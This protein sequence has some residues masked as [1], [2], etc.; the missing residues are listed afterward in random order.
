M[1][2]FELIRVAIFAIL[3]FAMVSVSAAELDTRE[4]LRA[5]SPRLETETP[6]EPLRK[7]SEDMI[8]AEPIEYIRYPMTDQERTIVE[9]VVAAES[10]GEDFDGQCLVAQCIL[11]TA[12]ATGKRPDEVVLEPGQYATPN[13]DCSHLVSEAVSAVFDDG[14]QVTDEPVRYFYAPAWG[15][16]KWHETKLEF[17]LEHGGHRFFKT[18]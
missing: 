4:D 8:P 13:Y 11:N 7:I 16:S 12:E 6:A 17:V 10:M 14:Y 3:I 1:K 5:P 18:K 15:T 9:A 2:T